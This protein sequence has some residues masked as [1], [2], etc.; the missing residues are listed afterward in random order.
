SRS[1][2]QRIQQLIR[3]SPKRETVALVVPGESGVWLQRT[4]GA[5]PSG[6]SG[7]AMTFDPIFGSTILFGGDD[8]TFGARLAD[9][10]KWHGNI[11]AQITTNTIPPPRSLSPLVFDQTRG[12]GV[13]F[14]GDGGGSAAPIIRNDTWEWH[15]TLNNWIPPT[16]ANPPGPRLGHCMAWDQGRG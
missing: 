9:Q 3:E 16:V 1:P 11:W 4:T 13:M 15:P 6:R 2:S 5:P 12:V 7:P 14:G 10:W 8:G